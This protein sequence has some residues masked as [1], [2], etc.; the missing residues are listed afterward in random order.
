M[1][2]KMLLFFSSFLTIFIL[3]HIYLF[4][5]GWQA[6]P[7][8]FF[9]KVAFT[10]VF[11][12]FSISFIIGMFLG[13]KLP[14]PVT[15]FLQ[16]VGFIWLGAAVYFLIITAMFD[17]IRLL[18]HF[19]HFYPQRIISHYP[20]IKFLCFIITIIGVGILLIIGNI[21]F[22]NPVVQNMSL[23]VGKKVDSLQTLRI[24]AISDIHLGYTIQE[25]QL[26]KYIHKINELDPDIVL[27]A[28]DV[29]D[30]SIKP[31]IER[32]TGNM[33]RSVK[34]PLGIYAVLGNHEYI[35]GM[36]ESQA[37]IENE[38]GIKLLKDTVVKI[39]NSFYIVGRDDRTNP[40]RKSLSSLTE[41]LD[42]TLPV[43]L[44]DHQPYHLEISE[45]CKVDLQISGHTHNGQIWP[46]TMLIK[47][48][49]EVPYGYKKKGD[50]H[51]Y[52][53][54]GL[55]LWGPPFRIGSISEFC[56]IELQFNAA[57]Q[58]EF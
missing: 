13:D 14:I 17:L 46:L 18:N 40:S 22:R 2:T 58:D 54:S 16:N 32:K 25:A 52:V 41:H 26:S 34:A 43:I 50:T 6:L 51:I 24:V 31:L 45:N 5:R 55:G 9:L 29:V 8:K 3:V 21:R 42:K 53:S 10:V 27:I 19:I 11:S 48:M 37:Y 20:M 30:R 36:K 49:Y 56:L 23:K 1:N 38:T 35:G 47:N 44:L 15:T 12:T 39:N 28:G 57:S 7:N 4:L 33:F